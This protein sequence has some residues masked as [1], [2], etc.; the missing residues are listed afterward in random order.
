MIGIETRSL[1]RRLGSEWVLA[2]VSFALERGKIGLV[3]GPNGSGKT[4]LLRCLSTLSDFDHGDVVV[5]G[6]DARKERAAARARMSV[7]LDEIGA[8]GDLS[9]F[10][11]LDIARNIALETNPANPIDEPRPCVERAGLSEALA[12]TLPLRACSAGMKRRF[13]F[14]RLFM[15]NR[16]VALLDEPEAHLDAAG[17]ALVKDALWKLRERGATILLA[18]HAVDAFSDLANARFRLVSGRLTPST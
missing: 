7:V 11:N 15:L 17:L 6:F 2:R 13:Q 3:T 18:T 4:T 10:E 9:A 5:D 12:R 1:S 14:A 16:P 8:Y